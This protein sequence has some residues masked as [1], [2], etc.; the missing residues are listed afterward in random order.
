[1]RILFAAS[2]GIPFVKGG[3]QS[4]MIGY[5]PKELKKQKIDV[6][7][8]LPNYGDIPLQLRERMAWKMNFTV[9]LAWR[10]QFCDL[11]ELIY[12]EVPYYFIDSK[13]YFN[14]EGL[15]G[16]DDDAE[17]YAFFCRAVLEALPHLDFQPQIIHCHDWQTGMISVFLKTHY[18]E[19]PFYKNIRTVFTIHNLNN[20]GIFS[21]EIL[22][23]LLS[24]GEEYF[25]M[26][27]LEFYGQL[28]YMKGGLSF[29]DV[30]TTVS[31]T[32]A[33]EIQSSYFGKNLDGFLRKRQKDLYG[34][35]NGIDYNVYNP[36]TDPY[37]FTTY[38][39]S[40]RKKMENKTK[41]QKLL[42]LPVKKDIPL[43]AVI[44]PFNISRGID[45]II[46]GIEELL[47]MDIQMVI[48]GKGDGK[49][50]M[51]LMHAAKQYPDKVSVNIS[52]DESLARKIYAAS[53]MFLIPSLIEPCCIK[54]LIALRYGSIPIVSE[55]GSLKDTIQPFDVNTGEGNGF[56]FTG[57]KLRD[58]IEVTKKAINMFYNK[59]LWYK[60]I[61]NAM[62]TNYGWDKTAK[63]YYNLYEFLLDK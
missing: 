51:Q 11:Q 58:M 3:I 17:R 7:V 41:L 40:L 6:R 57:Y 12:D 37:I 44:S 14:R 19:N 34:I 48:M 16:F 52:L 45:M 4:D 31:K 39:R 8:I 26:E 10:N 60:I 63:Q 46:S 54:Q 18:N 24:L 62:K 21:K 32:Y 42:N 25:T 43:I 61:K 15:Y 36:A 29:S 53:D 28:S 38:Q 13:Y 30:L 23:D 1:M 56:K 27:M 2:E 33:E 22:G 49:Y 59:E 55:T 50:E 5:L 35:S 9:P 20:Q 47:T